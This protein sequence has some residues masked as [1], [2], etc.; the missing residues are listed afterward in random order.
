ML[1]KIAIF[2]GAIAL[3]IPGSMQSNASPNQT[4]VTARMNCGKYS[5]G[6]IL[7]PEYYGQTRSGLDIWICFETGSGR[8]AF[9]MYDPG[10]Y[11]VLNCSMMKCTLIDWTD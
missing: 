11:A 10:P 1:K 3:M 8:Q 9:T 7:Y 2:L 6:L 4:I 5:K